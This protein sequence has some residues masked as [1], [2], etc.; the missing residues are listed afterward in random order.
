[1]RI[2]FKLFL[3]SHPQNEIASRLKV[4]PVKTL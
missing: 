4:A 2:N 1:M 3:L